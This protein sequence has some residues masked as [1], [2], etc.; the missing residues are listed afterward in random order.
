MTEIELNNECIQN[1]GIDL[2]RY[3]YNELTAIREAMRIYSNRKLKIMKL[4]KKVK[5]T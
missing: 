3:T 5:Q 1:A 2:K 4:D